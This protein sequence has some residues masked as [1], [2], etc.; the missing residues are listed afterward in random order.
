MAT[1][2]PTT[3]LIADTP[4]HLLPGEDDP[5]PVLPALRHLLAGLAAAAGDG[6]EY[7][8]FEADLP[9]TIGGDVDLCV[10]G[11]HV[12]IRMAR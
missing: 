7:F 4:L 8:Y 9:G 3:D 11:G 1:C 10:H 2:H 12:L 5:R 6:G